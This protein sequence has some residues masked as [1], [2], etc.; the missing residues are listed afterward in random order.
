M[1]KPSNHFNGR[2]YYNQ[3]VPPR[4]IWEVLF[5]LWTRRPKRWPCVKIDQKKIQKQRTSSGEC[6][7]TFINHSTVLLQ[8]EGRNILTDPIWSERASPFSWMG[9][10][11]VGLPGIKFETFLLLILFF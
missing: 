6:F 2:R 5:W 10:K 4:S 11:R 7:V 3:G 9:P 8:I 1:K